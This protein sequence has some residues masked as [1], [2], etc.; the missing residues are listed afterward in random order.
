MKTDKCVTCGRDII[1]AV[2]KDG[3]RIPVDARPVQGGNIILAEKLYGPPVAIILKKKQ[4]EVDELPLELR[5]VTHFAS[6][7][8]KKKRSAPAAESFDNAREARDQI[9]ED[10]KEHS[11]D[12]NEAAPPAVLAYLRV[13]IEACC[14]EIVDHLKRIGLAP[15]NAKDDRAYG[16]VFSGL[17]RRKEIVRVGFRPRRK[18]HL[19]PGASIWRLG[20]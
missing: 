4:M 19:A 8:K 18:G 9:L 11:P 7:P 5:Y 6:C 17:A 13:H 10:H 16:S 15:E 2:T 14:E 3:N 12:F 1:W 20:Q